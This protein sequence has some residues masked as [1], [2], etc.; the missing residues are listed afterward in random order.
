[1][2]SA[3]IIVDLAFCV[4][5]A[6]AFNPV[7]KFTKKFL[8][9]R[10]CGVEGPVR[11]SVTLA[12]KL[13]ALVSGASRGDTEVDRVIAEMIRETEERCQDIL[14]KGKRE[15]EALLEDYIHVATGK[16]ELRIESFIRTLRVSAVETAASAAFTL[17]KEE[18]ENGKV[19]AGEAVSASEQ[20]GVA[21]KKLH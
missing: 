2:I 9:K 6:L 14:E 8:A 17:M 15:I 12:G 10:A 20:D 3:H 11:K 4:G 1:M 21:S 5:F 18:L 13:D 16:L 7:R 19:D